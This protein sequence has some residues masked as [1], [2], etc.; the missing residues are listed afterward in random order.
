LAYEAD[1]GEFLRTWAASEAELTGR[2]RLSRQRLELIPPTPAFLEMIAALTAAFPVD[3]HRADLVILKTARANAALEGRLNLLPEDVAAGAEL[4][5]PHRLKH[6]PFQ[7]AV[8][9]ED[10]RYQ[11]RERLGLVEKVTAEDLGS[12]AFLDETELRSVFAREDDPY[13]NLRTGLL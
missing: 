7:D 3:R 8:E 10:M 4:A 5:L 6:S 12:G 11:I 9:A 1:P 2:I 13:K